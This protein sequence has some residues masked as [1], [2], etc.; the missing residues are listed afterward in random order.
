MS[1][2][3]VAFTVIVQTVP[4]GRSTVGSSVKLLAGDALNV[5]GVSPSPTG[6]C[7]L[8]ELVVALTGSL[9]LMTMFERPDVRRRAHWRRVLNRRRDIAGG[10]RCHGKI[11][12]CQSVIAST[13]IRILPPCRDFLSGCDR[14]AS[15]GIWRCG[16][17]ARCRQARRPSSP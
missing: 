14:D 13:V 1:V 8:N 10:G 12:D 11:V 3:W 17:P 7:R 16:C 5:N 15:V 2:I 9:K 4:N 6:H